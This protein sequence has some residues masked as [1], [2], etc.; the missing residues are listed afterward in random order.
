MSGSGV[1]ALS[2]QRGRP[3]SC[4]DTL[5]G[6][7]KRN[8]V[9][10]RFEEARGWVTPSEP[11]LIKTLFR[12]SGWL[13]FALFLQLRIKQFL[14]TLVVEVFLR[15]HIFTRAHHLRLDLVSLQVLNQIP[16]SQ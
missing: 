11:P 12:K 4:A 3:C 15:H 2:I 14:G 5:A 8:G 9:W 6:L 10:R 1:H 7:P 13:D 16:D